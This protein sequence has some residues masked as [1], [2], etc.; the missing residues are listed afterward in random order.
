MSNKQPTIITATELKL[1][2][3]EVIKRTCQDREHFIVERDGYAVIA[4]I[5]LPVYQHCVAES[6]QGPEKIC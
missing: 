1:R 2:S 6:S 4:I 5:P 3:G